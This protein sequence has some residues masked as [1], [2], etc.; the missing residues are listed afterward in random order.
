MDGAASAEPLSA[1]V[2]TVG[3]ELD[4]TRESLS[5]VA[6]PIAVPV[7]PAPPTTSTGQRPRPIPTGRRRTR[8]NAWIAPYLRTVVAS[9]FVSAA[10]AATT[11]FVIKVP[12][13]PAAPAFGRAYLPVAIALPFCWLLALIASDAYDRRILGLGPDEFQR[14]GRAFVILM[15][16]VGF[17]SYA[18]QAGIGRGF[19]VIALPM[20]ALLSMLGRYAI[21]KR[22]HA[23]RRR[24]AVRTSVIAV[25]DAESVA[26]LAERINAESYIGMHVVGACVPREELTDPAAQERLAAAGLVAFGDLDSVGTA[27]HRAKADTVAVASSRAM[28][29]Q[30]LRTLSWELENLDADLIVA[31][32]LMEVAGPRLHIRPVT[33]LPLLQVEKPEFSGARRVVK[34][35]ADRS[36]AILGL[37]LFSP[38]LLGVWLA[39]RC[40]SSGPAFFTQTRVGKNGRE[41]RIWKFRSMYLD[42]EQRKSDYV[43]HND[44]DGLLFK[45]RLD[46][47]VTK[48][49]RVIRRY[50]LDELPQLFNVLNGTMSM[51]G[52]RPPLPSEV[53]QYASHVHRRLLVRPGVT[54][55]WQVSGR[56]DLSW[57]ESVRLDLRYVEN[58]SLGLDA[59]ILWKTASAV[60]RGSGA[61]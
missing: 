21:R 7:I 15:A 61:Y 33:G 50:S 1:V 32:G 6:E 52:P 31:P 10:L 44:H 5:S 54:G 14:A 29:P 20:T 19:V 30:R 8:G 40:T 35:L 53:E 39:V 24:G 12:E 58:W 41:F 23:A 51:V 28:S 45:M 22:L 13:G 60:L 43:A 4:V 18:F 57:E 55:L 47:R 16:F 49:G 2:L 11:A 27:V 36:A 48:I 3:N 26:D 46:P 34:G 9:D 56:S 37:A 17:S 25:G 59:Q 42:A 38:L